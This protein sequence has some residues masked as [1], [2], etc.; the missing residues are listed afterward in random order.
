MLVYGYS[1]GHFYQGDKST[2][3]LKL[4]LI[5]PSGEITNQLVNQLNVLIVLNKFAENDTF[6]SP[7]DPDIEKSNITNQNYQLNGESPECACS[8]EQ[9]CRR[10]HF[11]IYFGSRDRKV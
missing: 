5:P 10:E 11:S 3:T 6:L 2:G 7:L 8:F 9:L 4:Y 1:I